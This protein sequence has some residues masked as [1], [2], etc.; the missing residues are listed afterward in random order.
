MFQNAIRT[1]R[2]LLPQSGS[3]SQSQV[4]EAVD[5]ILKIPVYRELD[6]ASLIRTIEELYR[7][8]Q[9]DYKIIEKDERRN[10]WL[11]EKRSQINFENGFWGRYR[12]YLGDEKN[13]APDTINK[14]DRLADKIL[15]SLFDPT[16]NIQIDK[17]GL[18][19][20][21]VQSGK[22]SNYTGLICKA[23][24][25]GFKLIIVLAGIHN[26]LR[27]QTQLRLDEGF[28]GFD[29]QHARA[30]DQNNIH[31]GVGRL[32]HQ[33][34][35]HSLTSSLEKGDFTQGAANALG[36][37]FNTNEPIIAVIKKNP[38]VLRRIY[39]WLSAQATEGTDIGRIIRNKSLLLI[40]DEAD[41]AS[42]NISD[43]PDKRSAINGWITQI[44]KLFGKN[45][46]V[47]YTATPFANIFIP[48]EDDNLFPRDFIINIPAPSN[49][50]GPEKIFGFNFIEDEQESDTIL[51]LINHINDYENFVPNR[52]KKEDQLPTNLPNSLKRSI[53]CFII[54]CAIR[55]LRGQN[56]VHN[57][58]LVHV[59]LYPRW[60][61]HIKEL[62]ENQFNYYR[63]GIDQNDPAII[64]EFRNTFETDEVGY[65]SYVTVSDQILNSKLTS[66]DSQ[67][68]IHTWEDV[69][70]HLNDA[71]S[72]IEVKVIHGGSGEAL[73]YY[74]HKNG[75]SVIVVGGNKLSRGMTLEGLSVSY[76]LRASKMYD[77]LMQMGRWFGYRGGYIDL[78]RLFTSRE[79]NE[80]F[81]HITHAS[82]ELREEFDY[83]SDVAGSTPEQYALKVRTH[84]GVLQISASNKLRSA[85]TVQI[86]WS[87]RLIESYELKKDIK[88]I[89]NN[90]SNTQRFVSNLP[91][92]FKENDKGY[93]WYDIPADEIISFLGGIQSIENLKSYEPQNLIRFINKQ[94]PNE[95]LIQWRVALMSK[96]NAS[97]STDFQISGRIYKIGQWQRTQDPNNSDNSVYYLRKSH[98]ISPKDEFIDLTPQEYENAMELT[99]Q[100]RQKQKKDGEPA[101]PNGEIVRNEI[102]DPKKPLLLIYLLDPIESNT[103]IPDTSKPFVGYA[104]SFPKSNYNVF[105][106]FAVNEELL[107]RFDIEDT[108]DEYE[109][110]EE[111]ED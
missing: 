105:E 49:Y 66:I 84:P 83:M 8:R 103:G 109:D 54:T 17:K 3:I 106:S 21:Q 47:G 99:R 87:G 11:N 61:D 89:N 46:Y 64:E 93:L 24:D 82:E 19:V 71:A 98:I 75:L 70:F 5:S 94:L 45:G 79:I 50:I 23:A 60:H 34:V 110:Y 14:L 63:R 97:S 68:Q 31:I 88:V 33:L 22:T 67:I 4:V 41:N 81:C 48:L 12:D 1:I 76:Y 44:L 30:F 73:D 39:Q 42:I 15:D 56:T 40:D 9:D 18:V 7:I 13:F 57:S 32:G 29:T 72:R 52:H 35:A 38:H 102:R 65:K 37:N 111:N 107:D 51:P 90:L 36:L 100:K 85:V 53:R 101:Y 55:R 59:S 10:P 43:D 28:L 58:M 62:I 86:S 25:S 27:S 74:E 80:W 69:L 92:N 95:E 108:F 91:D 6:K 16:K 77:T 78:C 2:T 96:D 20:G 104:I 26:N